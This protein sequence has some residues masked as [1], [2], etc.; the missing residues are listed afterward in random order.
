MMKAKPIWIKGKEK[1]MNIHAVFR[2]KAE[3]SGKGALRVAGTAFYRIILNGCFLAAGPARAAGG[4][5]REDVFSLDSGNYEIIIEAVGYHCRSLSTVCQTSYIMAEITDGDMLKAC[6]GRDFEGFLPEC[7]LQKVERYSVQRHFTEIWDFRNLE[8]LTDEKYKKEL[9]EITEKPT[10]LQR[11]AA[12]P[13]YND[14]MLFSAETAGELKFDQGLPYKEKRYSWAEIPKEWGIFEWDEIPHP[15]TWIQRQEQIVKHRI[16]KLP[17]TLYEGEYAIFDFGEIEAG[18]ILTD[19]S[20]H[21]ES[22]IVIA[23]SEDFNA[24]L[25]Q[26]P[27]R[28]NVH[29]VIEYLLPAGYNTTL[30]SFEPYTV[31]SLII[32]VKSGNITVNGAGIKTYMHDTGGAYRLNSGSVALNSI[33]KAAV[34]TFSHNSV[35]LYYDCPSRERAGWLCDSYFTAKAEYRLTGTT[36]T[37]DAYL[38]NYRLF[39]NS[40][41]YPAGV[42]PECYPSDYPPHRGHFIPQW[43]MWYILEAEEYINKR[44]HRTMAEDFR[45][46]IYGLLRFYKKFENADGLLERLEGWNFV[47][48]SKANE[49]TE[50]VNYPTQFL[51]AQTLE[52]VYKIYG[53]TDCLKHAGEVRKTAERQSFNGMFFCDHA[54]RNENGA[55]EVQGGHISEACQYYAILFGNINI[56]SEKYKK[57]RDF[58][59]AA[60]PENNNCSSEIFRVNAFIGFYLRMETLLKM[61]EYKILLSDI[62]K[63]F[64]KMEGYSGTLWEYRDGKGSKDHGFASYVLS[65][66][67]DSL[68]ATGEKY[69]LMNGREIL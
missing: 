66:I 49:W 25:F 26:V 4:Y 54:I 61:E 32:G 47:E 46:S 1:E 33:Y 38:E 51:Y 17:L 52:A 35:D 37:E 5:V 6:T 60:S 65:V 16:C 44:G 7:K 56:A 68:D 22:D 27:Q 34:R 23:F 24:E 20:A 43:T 14:I 58:V 31:R 12:Y 67:L 45:A 18:F 48:W 8:T 9:T 40:G 13:V 41:E 63:F 53:D 3:I 64:D 42:L 11:R 29:N 10:V 36:F 69:Q 50:D 28:M 57:L 15:Y 55:L 2:A 21:S 30:Q 39:K 19:M 62:E 59:L